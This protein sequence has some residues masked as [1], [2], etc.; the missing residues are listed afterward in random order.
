MANKVGSRR[1]GAAGIDLESVNGFLKFTS[2]QDPAAKGYSSQAQAEAGTDNDSIMTPLRVA[3]AIAA[4]SP[5]GGDEPSY[6]LGQASAPTVNDNAGDTDDQGNAIRAGTLWQHVKTDPPTSE[7]D[8]DWYR[9]EGFTSG[10]DAIWHLA[11]QV[12]ASVIT[13]IT[14]DV[15]TLQ[16][17]VTTL[18]S[19]MAVVFAS[20][21]ESPAI[22]TASSTDPKL[23]LDHVPNDNSTTILTATS[24]NQGLFPIIEDIDYE[25]LGNWVFLRYQADE[26]LSIANND[27][28]D[29]NYFRNAFN[30][31]AVQDFD[32]TAMNTIAWTDSGSGGDVEIYTCLAA[33][34]A[35]KKSK[36]T[37]VATVAE[38]DE[39]YNHS[40]A[41]GDRVVA[42]L[43]VG[44][45]R[46]IWSD[47]DIA[48]AA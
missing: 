9:C 47:V 14:N 16:S 27:K 44:T 2:G 33:D 38:A 41:S 43:K 12:A 22:I 26:S 48:S 23:V 6:L 1:T 21:Y 24:G 15:S 5:A 37:L 28:I 35:T 7:A 25:L 39:T 34:D 10:G 20:V 36:W 32:G 30:P 42:R 3:Q 13:A 18:T 40:L 4:L 45:K 19:R 46:G 11:E 8:V 17:T 31:G 29:M